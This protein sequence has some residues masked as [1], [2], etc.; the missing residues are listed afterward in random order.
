MGNVECRNAMSLENNSIS[1]IMNHAQQVE[2]DKLRKQAKQNKK[3]RTLNYDYYQH[4]SGGGKSLA[5][6]AEVLNPNPFIS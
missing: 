2:C 6:S 4:K 3:Y 5:V 1:K